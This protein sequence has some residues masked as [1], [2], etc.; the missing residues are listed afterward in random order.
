MLG[1][2]SE[3][4]RSCVSSSFNDKQDL[5]KMSADRYQTLIK[6]KKLDYKQNI[7]N[8]VPAH[9][10]ESHSTFIQID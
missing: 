4:S 1:G 3:G 9:N 8:K 7:V 6:K 5:F 10:H 2:L